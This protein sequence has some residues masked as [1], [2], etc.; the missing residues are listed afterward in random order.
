[1]AVTD[2]NAH[3]V[4][5]NLRLLEGLGFPRLPLRYD[6]PIL[7]END[8][9]AITLLGELGLGNRTPFVAINAMT[10]WPTKNWTPEHFA[11]VADALA[12]RGARRVYRCHCDV[13]A[14]DAIAGAMRT[15]PCRLDGRTSLKTLG[16]IFRRAQVVL[17]TDTG[18]MHIAVAVG[19][20]WSRCS[21]RPPRLHGTAR[22]HTSSS[23]LASNA[24]P[25]TNGCARRDNTRTRLHVAIQ[26]EEVV[27]AVQCQL[28]SGAKQAMER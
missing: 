23:A 11:A 24:A 18:P 2:P 21:A 25:A 10:R 28:D 26:P 16:A 17:S 13:E 3:A 19:T 8:A 7:P 1:V 6:F 4:E 15:R 27:Q 14:L 5:R 22:R 12:E 20:W 9:E